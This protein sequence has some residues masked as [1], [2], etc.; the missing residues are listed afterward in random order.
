[1]TIKVLENKIKNKTKKRRKN[2]LKKKQINKSRTSSELQ[3][4]VVKIFCA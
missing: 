2:I 1:M 3:K 4:N